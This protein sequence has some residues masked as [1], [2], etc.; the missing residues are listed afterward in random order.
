MSCL[1]FSFIAI[2]IAIAIAF[3]VY[4]CHSVVSKSCSIVQQDTK[5]FRIRGLV[6]I[7][8]SGEVAAVA[9]LWD[10]DK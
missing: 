2:A 6:E 9:Q 10:F 8:L 3:I 1:F 7:L 4:F 5:N